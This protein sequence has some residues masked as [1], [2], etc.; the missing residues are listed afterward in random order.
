MRILVVD[1]HPIF[2][3]GVEFLLNTHYPH[4][5]IVAV[6]DAV[7]A[8]E[9]LADQAFD[10]VILDLNLPGMDG[11]GLLQGMAAQQLS[12]PTLTMSAETDGAKILRAL[13]YGALGFVPKSFKPQ[14]M[15]QAINDVAQGKVFLPA[16]VRPLLDRAQRAEQRSQGPDQGANNGITPRQVAVLK[17][18]AQG[19][20][21]KEIAARL[22]LTEYTV[23]SHV[24]GLFIALGCKNRTACVREAQ[25]RGILEVESAS[26]SSS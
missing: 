20:S 18:V 15:L 10:L 16:S 23:K 21:N 17:L 26:R 11:E 3:A 25:A 4:S 9:Q 5:H 8:L 24:R 19:C 6:A 1:D 13:Q 2:L 12:V 7:A 22:N 14:Q